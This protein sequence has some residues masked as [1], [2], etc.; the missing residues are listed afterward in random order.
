MASGSLLGYPLRRAA[1]QE[2]LHGGIRVSQLLQRPPQLHYTRSEDIPL[3]TPS[4][5]AAQL[6][7]EYQW[8]G[9][10]QLPINVGGAIRMQQAQIRSE[11]V[12]ERHVRGRRTHHPPPRDLSILP[13]AAATTPAASTSIGR[14]VF[15]IGTRFMP[16]QIIKPMPHNWAPAMRGA[17]HRAPSASMLQE[18]LD[19]KGFGQKRKAR[20]LW[21]QDIATAGFRPKRY[22]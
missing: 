18:R 2:M 4:D 7:V 6:D 8:L 22:Y 21:Q 9:Y 10:R 20:S 3:P 15:G 17:G 5:E 13:P 1:A 19:N 12:Y 16:L 11:D 14:T